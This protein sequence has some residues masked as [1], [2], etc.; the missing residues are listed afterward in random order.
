MKRCFDIWSHGR[1]QGLPVRKDGK[2]FFIDKI[3]REI[4]LPVGTKF[5]W[6]PDCKMVGTRLD[7]IEGK[8]YQHMTT[9]RLELVKDE[10]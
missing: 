7:F 6:C 5:Y 4:S 9:P 3:G 1:L 8:K 2:Q 10:K